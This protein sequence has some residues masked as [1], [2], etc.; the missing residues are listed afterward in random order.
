METGTLHVVATSE[1]I[2]E[3]D[4]LGDEIAELAAHLDAATARLLELIR[5]FDARGGWNHGFRSCAHWL[6]YRAGIALGAAREHVRVARALGS[7]RLA[8]ALARGELSYSKVRALTRVA[9]PEPE[10]QLLAVGR[11]GTACHVERIVRGWRRVDRIA[12]A[13][14]NTRRQKARALHVYQDEDGMV[15][16]RG[17]L[18]PEQGAVVMQALAAAG[19]AL[20]QRTRTTS[21]PSWPEDVPAGT[22]SMEQQRADALTLLAEA[23]LHH[24]LDPGAPGERYQV[25]VHV[26]AAV[27]AD[28]EAPGQSVLDRGTHVPAETSQRLACDATRVIMRHDPDGR[29]VEVGARTRTIPPAIRRALHHRDGGCRFPGCGLPCGQGHHLRHWAHGGPTTLSNLAMLCRHHHRAVHEEGYKVENSRRHT[30]LQETGRATATRCTAAASGPPRSR[31]G[32]ARDER[33]VGSSAARANNVPRLAGRTPRRRVGDRRLASAGREA[34]LSIRSMHDGLMYSSARAPIRTEDAMARKQS[35]PATKPVNAESLDPRHRWDRPL[36]APGHMQVDFEERVDFRRLNA[37]RLARVRQALAGSGLGALL[38][39]D[40][41]NIRYISS[42]VIGEWARDKLTRWSLLTGTGEPWVWDF[43][44][45][46]RHHRLYAPWIPQKQSLA[47]M[48]GMRG[49]VS[50]K[51]GLFKQ[52]AKEIKDILKAEGVADMPLG[53]D[54]VEPP[55]LFE[56]QNVGIEVRDGQQVMLEARMIKSQDEL[57]LLNMAAAMVDGVYQ[58]IYEALKPGVRENEIVA[59]ATKRLYEMGSDCVE[60]INS[61]SGE[62]CSPHPHNFTDR[63]IRP[64]DQ[65]F[66]DIIMSFTGYRTCYYR[67]FNVGKATRAQSDAYKKAR[68]WMDEAIALIKPGVGTDK[69]AR[70]FP[71]APEIGFE[72]EM[73]AFGLNF[74]HGIG[75]GLHERPI[76]SR[77]NSFDDPMELEAGMMFA[78]ETYCPATDGVSAARIEEEVIVTPAGA[79]IITLFPANELPIANRY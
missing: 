60:A 9:T 19:E 11:A 34:A 79:Q 50:P 75:L 41:Y 15:V 72:S 21:T 26:D 66:F 55:F 78:V 18:T 56:L 8:D 33:S 28:A 1:A 70:A 49:A 27:L 62:R 71:K 32:A 25:V 36:Q 40:Q 6:G 22:S 65:A 69:I 5:E 76:I 42:T 39:F 58:D 53:I 67:T 73:A 16:I 46:A 17:R 37:Y 59:L 52:A 51:A 44:S 45:A 54:L 68:Q 48:V 47:G 38:V 13:R 57:T 63:I 74:C 7:P 61:I 10:E 20:Y 12:E 64:G 3:L 23:A 43:G 30:A 4:R 14:D 77:L 31:R 29:I 35:A 24:S 2:A